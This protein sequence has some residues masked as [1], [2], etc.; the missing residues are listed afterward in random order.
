[1]TARVAPRSSATWPRRATSAPA[2]VRQR[3]ERRGRCESWIWPGAERVRRGAQLV[4]GGDD[5]DARAAR[6]A[7]A[8]RARADR[9]ARSRPGRA[10]C[11]RAS[12]TSPARR[13]SPAPRTLRPGSTASSAARRRLV[14]LD[15]LDLRSTAS[16][17]AGSAA[18]V[19][20]RIASPS[21]SVAGR[22]APA[23]DSPMSRRR[24]RP[25]PRARRSRPWR[26]WRNA[27]TSCGRDDVLGQDE[28]ER[29]GHVDVGRR[30]RR[31][32]G[33]QRRAGLVDGGEVGHAAHCHRSPYSR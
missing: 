26:C 21:P 3:A 19:E 6:A 14:E 12:T 20:M 32:G 11:P 9:H 15:E 4:A 24:G 33:Q 29:L 8:S 1:M 17:P 28:A 22:G 10:A 18:P 23:R 27:G 5:R 30:Q 2:R 7:D 13:S 25:R 31:D 16:A